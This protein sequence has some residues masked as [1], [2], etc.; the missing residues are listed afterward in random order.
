MNET[1]DTAGQTTV[2]I[3]GV[4]NHGT[5]IVVLLATDDDRVVPVHFDHRPFR[6]LLEGE[7]CTHEEL[8]G[9]TTSFDGECL[10][11]IE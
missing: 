4:I 8:I 11:F 6:W 9:R 3:A 10:N 7:Q 1:Q 5:I 2:T